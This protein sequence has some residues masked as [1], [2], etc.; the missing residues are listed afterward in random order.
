MPLWGTC[1]ALA[2]YD[3]S[4]GPSYA[5]QPSC[6][7]DTFGMPVSGTFSSVNLATG[8]DPNILIASSYAYYGS[9]NTNTNITQG[10]YQETYYKKAYWHKYR[11]CQ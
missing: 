3:D 8:N 6:K 4:Y 10:L 7:E 1:L 2:R 9:A 5:A 11:Q